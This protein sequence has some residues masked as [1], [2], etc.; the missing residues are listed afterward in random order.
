MKKTAFAISLLVGSGMAFA[1]TPAKKDAP[2]P[3]KDAKKEAPPAPPPKPTPAKELE[4]LKDWQKN[5]NCTATNEAGEKVTAKLSLKKE[6]DGFWVAIKF[7]VQKTKTMPAFVGMGMIGI[8][9]VS[10]GWVFG[11]YDSHGGW[12]NMKGKE[13]TATSMVWDGEAGNGAMGKK[14]PAKLSMAIGDKK[15]MTFTGEFAGKKAFEH[16]CK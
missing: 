16:T 10:K 14:V 12:I 6:L 2:A 1:D 11:G 15:V 8:D 13:A 3:A 7:D 9:P 5:W 4:V